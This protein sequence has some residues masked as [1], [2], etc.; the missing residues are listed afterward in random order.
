MNLPGIF[1]VLIPFVLLLGV[2]IF[3]HELGHFAVAKWLGVKV[4]KFSIGFGPSLFSR[5]VGETEYVRRGAAARRLREDAGRDSGRG[6][7]ARR[8]RR[9]RSTS[10][11]SG[12]AS[13]SRSRGR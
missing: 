12:S 8:G 2:L 1:D 3:I 5:T 10:G 6:A 4:E 7:R 9:A 13:R 11:P